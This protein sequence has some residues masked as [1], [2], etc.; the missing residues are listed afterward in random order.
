MAFKKIIWSDIAKLQFR[1]ILEFY[2]ERNKSVTYSLKLLK[3]TEDLL[4]ILSKNE[5]IGRL[6]SNKSTRVIPFKAYLIFYDIRDDRIE[7]ISYWDNRQDQ[8]KLEN[9]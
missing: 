1:D 6:T 3:E 2:T 8:S 9:P 5:F 4:D 7:I